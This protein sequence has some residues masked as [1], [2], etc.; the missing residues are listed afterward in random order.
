MLRDY[1]GHDGEAYETGDQLHNALQDGIYAGGW[2]A[3]P[4]EVMDGKDARGNEAMADHLYGHKDEGSLWNSFT[5]AQSPS[6]FDNDWYWTCSSENDR[7]EALAVRLSNG[8]RA[9]CVK[10]SYSHKCRL[11]RFV[12]VPRGSA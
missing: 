1:H 11:V 12:E 8:N 4:S 6:G 7:R 2:V 3:P 5:P 10:T 9:S